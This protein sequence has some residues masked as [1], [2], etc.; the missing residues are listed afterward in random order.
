MIASA[1]KPIP[2]EGYV[3][4]MESAKAHDPI[5]AELLNEERGG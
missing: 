2:S 3:G 4:P 5:G 1:R